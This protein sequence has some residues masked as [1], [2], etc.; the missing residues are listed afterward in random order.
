MIVGP[1]LNIDFCVFTLIFY[2]LCD[3]FFFFFFWLDHFRTYTCAPSNYLR[4]TLL[5]SLFRFFAE[6]N[7]FGPVSASF[8]RPE[9]LFDSAA[10]CENYEDTMD[11]TA[12]SM[13]YRSLVRSES[14]EEPKTPTAVSFAFGEKTPKTP[15]KVTNPIDSGGSFM[16][17]T[18]PKK[19]I[20]PFL[21]PVGKARDV[22][23]SNDM[24]IV[25]ENPNRFDYGRLSPTT[26]ALL[27]SSSSYQNETG[28][29]GQTNG[30]DSELGN[31][32]SHEK[33][34]EAASVD[35]V[36]LNRANGDCLVRNVDDCLSD[37]NCDLA[38]AA[39]IDCQIQSPNRLTRV[40]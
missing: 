32:A 12:F 24:S 16:E 1:K 14:G 29:V 3:F 36:E 27:A 37:N 23:D 11:T 6:D 35:G 2:L 25:E 9:Q 28:H 22:E 34:A 20:S 19:L 33:S 4:I 26:E 39:S 17:I 31:S 10:S 21:V 5:R 8:I 30:R 18:E 13:H 38:A 7:F 40:R 15:P